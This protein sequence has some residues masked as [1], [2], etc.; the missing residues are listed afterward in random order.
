MPDALN[1]ARQAEASSGGAASAAHSQLLDVEVPLREVHEVHLVDAVPTLEANQHHALAIAVGLL[2]SSQT[3]LCQS[4]C[5]AFEPAAEAFA[6][7][8]SKQDTAVRR[9]CVR[10]RWIRARHFDQ[11]LTPRGQIAGQPARSKDEKRQKRPS[12]PSKQSQVC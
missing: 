1:D 10:A 8:S 3:G 12:K 4:R 5:K 7:A 9:G 6:W 11:V 2:H